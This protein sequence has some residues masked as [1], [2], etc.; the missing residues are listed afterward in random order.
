MVSGAVHLGRADLVSA[1]V[2]DGR[3][4]LGISAWNDI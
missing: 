4:K 1:A 3:F 2:E